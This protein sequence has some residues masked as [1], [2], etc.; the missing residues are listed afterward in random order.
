MPP[1]KTKPKLDRKKKTDTNSVSLSSETS[2]EPIVLKDSSTLTPE[3]P[4]NGDTNEGNETKS[5]A[6]EKVSVPQKTGKQRRVIN[7]QSID[8]T[9]QKIEEELLKERNNIGNLLKMV[10]DVRKDYSRLSKEITKKGRKKNN[11][12]GDK[13][14]P[15]GALAPFKLDDELCTFLNKP[16]GTMMNAP[17]VIKA[18]NVYIKDK[19]LQG[20]NNKSIIM[21]DDKLSEL[22]Q[23]EDGQQLTYFNIQKYLA[24]HYI[25]NS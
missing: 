16:L 17:E 23:V 18:L 7:I 3:V 9:L 10:V 24:K 11:E 2:S 15:T 14:K 22:L 12:N 6:D 13:R 1:K 25:K 8:T 20:E 19:H 21:P 5:I 4:N